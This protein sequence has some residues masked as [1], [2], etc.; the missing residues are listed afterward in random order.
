MPQADLSYSAEITLDARAFLAHVEDIIS[1]HD[2]GAGACKGRAQALDVTHHTHILLR[3]RML[4]KAH[5][6]D[7]FLQG[8]LA[9]LQS[10]L[11][12]L[13]PGACILGIEIGFLEPH[14]ASVT[15]D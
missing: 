4:K 3:L 2:S 7:E 1:A 15:L 13:V 10:G 9:A 6:D 14:Y 5:R 8:L 11:R 12:P